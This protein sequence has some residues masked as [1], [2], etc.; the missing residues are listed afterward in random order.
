MTDL[1]AARTKFLARVEELASGQ[2]ARFAPALDELIAW[3]LE[4][5]LQFDPPSERQFLIRF[6]SPGEK[7]HLWVATPRNGDGAKLAVGGPAALMNDARAELAKIDARP[8]DEHRAPE[9]AFT[10]L[11]WGPYRTA[12]LELLGRMLPVSA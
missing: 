2:A 8:V 12:V 10:Y 6:R 3:S 7:G 5:G 4:R 11:I 9:V 1:A